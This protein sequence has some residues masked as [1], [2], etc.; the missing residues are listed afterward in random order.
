MLANLCE[1]LTGRIAV[2]GWDRV[3]FDVVHVT[4]A[5]LRELWEEGNEHVDRRKDILESLNSELQYEVR[6]TCVGRVWSYGA[7]KDKHTVQVN[8][9]AVETVP[10]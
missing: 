5:K 10:E 6:A 1:R 9:N 3:C 4:D 8:I 2:T 7:R